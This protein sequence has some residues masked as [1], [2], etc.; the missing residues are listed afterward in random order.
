MRQVTRALQL[1]MTVELWIDEL[2]DEHRAKAG[3]ARAPIGF[4]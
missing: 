3:A 4:M 2:E 1:P